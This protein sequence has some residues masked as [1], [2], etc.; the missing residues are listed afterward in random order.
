MSLGILMKA[1]NSIH[2]REPIDFIFEF[3]PQLT[4]LWCLFGFMDVLIVLKWLTPWGESSSI[5]NEPP[6]IISIMINMFLNQGKIDKNVEPL[7]HS[8]NVQQLVS[9]ILLLTALACVPLML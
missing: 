1:M 9:I 8:G 7:I 5:V 3:L 2:F 4:L 6:S